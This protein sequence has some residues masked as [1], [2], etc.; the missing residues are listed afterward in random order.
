[1]IWPMFGMSIPKKL[2][3]ENSHQLLPVYWSHVSLEGK[4]L[5]ALPIV[6]WSR[7]SK[8]RMLV[9]VLA[10]QEWE[11]QQDER[12]T[13]LAR[14]GNKQAMWPASDLW[15]SSFRIQVQNSG[16]VVLVLFF[17]ISQ[18]IKNYVF[19]LPFFWFMIL[20][21]WLF[22]KQ[23]L[24]SL[25]LRSP[26]LRTAGDLPHMSSI[27]QLDFHAMLAA[28]QHV[29]GSHN[30]HWEDGLD[31]LRHHWA[32]PVGWG[33][34]C[35]CLYQGGKLGMVPHLDMS[36]FTNSQVFINLPSRTWLKTEMVADFGRGRPP[37]RNR[38][39]PAMLPQRTL[40]VAV[41]VLLPSHV[42]FGIPLRNQILINV[43]SFNYCVWRR[44]PRERRWPWLMPPQVGVIWCFFWSCRVPVTVTR[45]WGSKVVSAGAVDLAIFFESIQKVFFTEATVYSGWDLWLLFCFLLFLISSY[46]TI[47]KHRQSLLESA[48]P[49]HP[50]REMWIWHDLTVAVMGQ[51]SQLLW[52]ARRFRGGA[53]SCVQ[54][55]AKLEITE[56][57]GEVL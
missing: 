6:A 44:K 12:R 3:S 13:Y 32:F 49:A 37:C 8:L 33:H 19:F 28:S 2:R 27:V 10:W 57:Y 5:W 51:A 56:R 16:W 23:F 52:F 53:R 55:A 54:V 17:W 7:P 40:A 45:H 9:E 1:M 47:Q 15:I 43:H 34:L 26:S 24:P 36:R 20:D 29:S 50:S 11:Q 25:L 42:Q 41:A 35:G 31:L 14:K 21:F 38:A 22:A 46:I 4:T 39:M 18:F 30:R 48:Y